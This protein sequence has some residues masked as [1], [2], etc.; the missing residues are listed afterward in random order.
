MNKSFRDL[1]NKRKKK[2]DEELKQCTFNP[3]I[4]TSRSN[5]I[6]NNVTLKKLHLK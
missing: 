3:I 2:Q 6:I 4:S 5:T 1:A